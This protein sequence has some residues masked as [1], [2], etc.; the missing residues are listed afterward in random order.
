MISLY[1]TLVLFPDPYIK[2]QYRRH[3]QT[4]SW[5][6]SVASNRLALGLGIAVL[7]A[8]PR[9]RQGQI[10]SRDRHL[11]AIERHE[12]FFCHGCSH[13]WYQYEHPGSPACPACQKELTEAVSPENDPRHMDDSFTSLD[14]DDSYRYHHSYDSNRDPDETDIEEQLFYFLGGFLVNP[15]FI[16]RLKDQATVADHE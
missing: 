6:S 15:L 1:L 3:P 7:V 11:D 16:S 5:L 2:R 10:V 13:E 12:I 14:L 9:S 8:Y 4:S